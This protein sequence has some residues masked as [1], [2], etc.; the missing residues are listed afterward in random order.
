MRPGIRLAALMGLP[1]IYVFTHDSIFVGEDG[2][3]HQPVEH[4]ASLRVIPGLTVIRPADANETAAAWDIT[5]EHREGPVALLLTRHKLPVLDEADAE[6]VARGGYVIA[7]APE[8]QIL[9][10]GSGSEVSVAM[11]AQRLLAQDGIPARVV[12]MP[13]WELFETQS[14]A[15]RDQ[16]LPP[17][18]TARVAV[19][20]GVP[21]GWDRYVGS[22]GEIIAMRR[23]GASAPY[24]LLAEEFGFTA[25]EVA[26]QA[27]V[28]LA[29]A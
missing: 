27:K 2:P 18:V 5:I 22:Q 7:D 28:C 20:A 8:P 15:Y 25:E 16:V 10:L 19:E 23:F 13:S 17:E 11:E 21:L 9:L 29:R 26:A 6:G 24:Q 14:Q 4:L 3:T 12:S 1:V